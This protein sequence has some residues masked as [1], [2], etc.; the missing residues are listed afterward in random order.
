LWNKNYQYHIS[1]TIIMYLLINP[2]NTINFA[3]NHPIREDLALEGLILIEFKNKELKEVVGNIAP[4]MAYWDEA[5]RRVI[6]D[7]S[8]EQRSPLDEAK[9]QIYNLTKIARALIFGEVDKLKATILS[10]KAWRAERIIAGQ[11]TTEDMQLLQI[12]CD[13]RGKNET[14]LELAKKQHAKAARYRKM[15]I[16]LDGLESEAITRIRQSSEASERN[17]II[18]ELKQKLDNMTIQ[19]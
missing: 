7:P 9:F 16:E 5:N 2:D 11:G 15:M 13:K 1:G 3:D 19:T 12:E 6:I 14:P 17:Q 10:D 8:I 18:S 4:D